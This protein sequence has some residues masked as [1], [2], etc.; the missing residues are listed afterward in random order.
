MD[1]KASAEARNGLQQIDKVTEIVEY[2]VHN[3]L[4]FTLRPVDHPKP[5]RIAL[6]GISS[7]AGVD[8]PAGIKIDAS[9]H[10]P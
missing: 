7:Y 4:P 3:Q 1:E 2:Y 6:D 5:S 10:V 9:R 8:R